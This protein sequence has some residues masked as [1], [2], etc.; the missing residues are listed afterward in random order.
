VC[1]GRIKEEFCMQSNLA[2]QYEDERPSEII[3][4]RVVMM[5]GASINHNRIAGNI[6]HI[7]SAFLRGKPCEPFGDGPELHL[8]EGEHYIPDGM[9]V[10]DKDKIK[11]NWVEGAP[12]LVV[13]VLSP[14]TAKNDRGLKKD[15]YE[16]AGVREYW[17]VEP[18]NRSIE[19]YLNRDGKFHLDNVYVVYPPEDIAEMKP[20]EQA[21]L[22]ESFKCSLFDDL[23]IRLE[24]VFD[25]V[26]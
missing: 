22:P 15:T 13:E 9:I 23:E 14:S 24:D 4:G 25:R 2:Y 26:I 10:C 16:R 5:A 19:V 6:H 11:R 12:D 18:S 3:D 8:E 1:R 21:A 7:F 20:E 17:I